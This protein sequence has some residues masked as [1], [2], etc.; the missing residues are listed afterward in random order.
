MHTDITRFKIQELHTLNTFS[1]EF[2]SIEYN[3]GGPATGPRFQLSRSLKHESLVEVNMST[4]LQDYEALDREHFE[5]DLIGNL[6]WNKF[7]ERIAQ[8]VAPGNT[9]LTSEQ[10]RLMQVNLVVA[11]IRSNQ[12]EQARKA[13]ADAV[14]SGNTLLALKGIG[15]FFLLR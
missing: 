14:A 12:L 13:W 10:R 7:A 11:L 8:Q 1:H 4:L 5:K 2:S 15:A 9:N 6:N 3:A